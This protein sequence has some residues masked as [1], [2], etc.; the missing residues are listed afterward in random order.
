MVGLYL[1]QGR[2]QEGFQ[3]VGQG[4]GQGQVACQHRAQGQEVVGPEHDR[5]GLVGVVVAPFLPQE[6][7]DEPAHGVHGGEDRHEKRPHVEAHPPEGVGEGGGEDGVLGP[8]AGKQGQA[9]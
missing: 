3:E 1:R 5:R 2:L 4:V 7:Q 8:E 6:D 9:P